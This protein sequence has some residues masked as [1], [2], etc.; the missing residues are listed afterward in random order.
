MKEAHK[1]K[2]GEYILDKSATPHEVL[3]ALKL[4]NEKFPS[5]S[6]RATAKSTS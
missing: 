1:I 4:A 2:A 6:L 3:K 5:L